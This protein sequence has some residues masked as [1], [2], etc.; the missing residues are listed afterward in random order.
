MWKLE[1]Q[2]DLSKASKQ[3]KTNRTLLIL[4][5]CSSYRV[6]DSERI[7]NHLNIK[8][9]WPCP[10]HMSKCRCK[11]APCR[12]GFVMRLGSLPEMKSAYNIGD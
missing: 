12:W 7:L 10:Q 5:F 1:R 9:R 2:G 8:K 3:A 11:D 6:L 4:V